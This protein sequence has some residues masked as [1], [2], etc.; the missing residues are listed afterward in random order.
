MQQ[1]LEEVQQR[2]VFWGRNSEKCFTDYG[3]D[4][5]DDDYGGDDDNDDDLLLNGRCHPVSYAHLKFLF[6]SGVL[7]SYQN[8]SP[9]CNPPASAPPVGEM[10]GM[11]HQTARLRDL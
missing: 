1:G 8:W 9:T 6:L 4:S 5:D 2:S 7:L 3:D 11:Y 10:I